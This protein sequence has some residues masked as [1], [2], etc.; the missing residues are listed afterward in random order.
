M[1][2]TPWSTSHSMEWR[3]RSTTKRTASSWQRPAPATCGVA[4]MVLEGVG[5]VEHG[6][7]PALGVG[8]GAFEQFV[9]GDEGHLAGGGE[10]QGGGQPGKAAADDEDVVGVQGGILKVGRESGRA[11]TICPRGSLLA[12][13]AGMLLTR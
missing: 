11:G 6:G 2:G 3:P 4:D 10:A 8:G 5:A 9:L 7:D 12:I 1:N 13:V